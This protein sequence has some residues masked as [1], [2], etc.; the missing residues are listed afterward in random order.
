MSRAAFRFDLSVYAPGCCQP[1][2]SHDHL[3]VSIAL[4]G[5]IA[6][7]VGDTIEQAFALSAVV[8]DPGVT[9]ADEFGPS[10]AVMARLS[11]RD[12]CFS[13]LADERGKAPAWRWIHHPEAAAPFLRLVER[14]T[15]GQGTFA[16]DDGDVVDLLSAFTS[17]CNAGQGVPPRWLRLAME[18]LRDT[19][20]STLTVRDVAGSAGV[21]PVYLAR[22]VRRWYGTTPAAELRSARLRRAAEAI[23]HGDDTATRIAHRH[24]F[25][26]QPHL[27]RVFGK[28]T[29]IT[30]GLFRRLVSRIQ[31]DARKTA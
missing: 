24:G 27:C 12:L 3:S 2:H 5:Q 6:E 18:Q 13:D 25:A 11:I 10:G 28:A 9:H 7:Q 8:K 29:G 20:A 23:A 19:A 4:R 26:D 15:R 30:P 22:A 16:V 1:A 31:G 21:H 17:R 14:A